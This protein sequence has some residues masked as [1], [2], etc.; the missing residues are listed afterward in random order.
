MKKRLLATAIA[1]LMAPVSWP[2]W[3][4]DVF[5][6]GTI[7][8]TADRQQVGEIDPEQASSVVTRKEI[9]T[10]NRETVADAVDLL[11][12]VHTSTN[13]RNEQTVYIRGYDPRQVPLFIDGIPV[14]VPYD[15]YVDFGRFDT[16]D[17]SAIQVAKGFSSVTYGANTLGGA[18]NLISRRPEKKLEGDVRMGFGE[19]STR[20]AAMNIGSN[21]GLWYIQAGAATR[22]ADGFRL[23]SDFKPTK[24]EDGGRRDNS[25]YSDSKVN[26]KV[27]LTPRGNDEYALTYT[28]QN[29]EKGQPPSTD[30]DRPR[31]WQWPEWNKESLY[32]ISRTG[33]TDDETL[34]VRAYV[35]KFDNT[36]IMYEDD[37]YSVPKGSESIYDDKTYGGSL[38]F[39]TRRLSNHTL[40]ANVRYKEDRHETSDGAGTL[41]KKYK[42]SQTSL[43]IEDNIALSDNLLLSVG[44]AWHY[45]KPDSVYDQYDDFALPDSQTAD[46]VQAGLFYDITPTARLYA[47]A[48]R[49][50]RLPTLKDRYSARFDRY[51]EN[52][53][54]KAEKANNYEIGYQGEPWYGAQAEAAVFWNDVDDKIQS[55]FLD[56][57]ATGRCGDGGNKCQMRNIGSA[58]FK[59]AELGLT[60]A[61][62]DQ[63]EVGGNATWMDIEN[64]TNKDIRITGVPEVKVIVHALWRP[65]PVVD[66]V[67]LGEHDNSRW[68][69]D[70]EKVSGFSKLNVKTAWRPAPGITTEVGVNNVADKNYELKDSYPEAGRMWFANISYSF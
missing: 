49:K 70:T 38:E 63:W 28:K 31:Y 1:S 37:T 40:R 35:D 69:S 52:P 3:A 42:D 65:V 18:I 51:I 7:T 34:K 45:L 53:D 54:L 20:R 68:V 44:Y 61:I 62:G 8:V 24:N 50:T 41:E 12:G 56:P 5:H 55:V 43:G 64:R 27:G 2:A 17:L 32:F 36:M 39:E 4:N 67:V 57:S 26:F 9:E 66:L 15:G 22:E 46:D 48:A 59:G 10:H 58:R 11:A 6:M 13:S 30:D 16:I 19:D 47:T 21:Q 29:G 14:Y 23:S 60:S 25:Y 33:L